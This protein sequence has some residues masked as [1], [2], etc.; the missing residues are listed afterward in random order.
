MLIKFDEKECWFELLNISDISY[1]PGANLTW[2]SSA[3]P[4]F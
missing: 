2:T 1:K 3:T 4:I